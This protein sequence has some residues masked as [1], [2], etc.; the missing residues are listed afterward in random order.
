MGLQCRRRTGSG[1]QEETGRGSPAVSNTSGRMRG[2]LH[3]TSHYRYQSNSPVLDDRARWCTGCA[4]TGKN[5]SVE[6]TA[7]IP[8]PHRTIQQ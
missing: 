3:P 8:T 1:S 5:F 7:P 2:E 4:T 6:Q